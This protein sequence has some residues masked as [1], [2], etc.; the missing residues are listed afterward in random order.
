MPEGGLDPGPL[1][2]TDPNL[3]TFTAASDAHLHRT[4]YDPGLNSVASFAMGIK[5]EPVEP[6]SEPMPPIPRPGPCD[7]LIPLIEPQSSG[8]VNTALNET[9]IIDGDLNTRWVSTIISTPWISVGL[10]VQKPVCKVDIAWADGNGKMYNFYIE[11]S[12]DRQKWVTILTNGQSAGNTNSFESFPVS[13][14]TTRYVRV[15]VTGTIPPIGGGKTTAQ[16]T[17]IRVFSNQ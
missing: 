4:Y 17:E 5:F 8:S 15:T 2:I 12:L 14:T 10:Q 13:V 16:M 1:I 6:G 7:R 9:K 11:S 3:Q